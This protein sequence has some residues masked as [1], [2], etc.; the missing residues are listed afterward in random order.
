MNRLEAIP[1]LLEI[2]KMHDLKTPEYKALSL[3]IADTIVASSKQDRIAANAE[4]DQIDWQQ[5]IASSSNSVFGLTP[6]RSVETP[7]AYVE[8][9]PSEKQ[10]TI[11]IMAT[12]LEAR[13]PYG[14]PFAEAI[15]IADEIYNKVLERVK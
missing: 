1:I 4:T 12:M 10:K 5:F 3:A 7:L 13:Y 11:A 15:R 2:R 8:Y 9:Q 14:S 6:E